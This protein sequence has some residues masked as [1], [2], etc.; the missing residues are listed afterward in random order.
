[1]IVLVRATKKLE[2]Y[3][4]TSRAKPRDYTVGPQ[5]QRAKVKSFLCV[6]CAFLPASTIAQAS[7]VPPA[8]WQAG[9]WFILIG[10]SIEVSCTFI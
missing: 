6:L 8:Y 9:L 10:L 2:R 5:V 3:T 4:I 7:F 1:M